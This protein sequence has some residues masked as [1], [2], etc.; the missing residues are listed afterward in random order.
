MRDIYEHIHACRY[1]LGFFKYGL[2]PKLLFHALQITGRFPILSPLSWFPKSKE[3]WLVVRLVRKWV[4]KPLTDS[5]MSSCE[6]LVFPCLW[7]SVERH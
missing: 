5:G 2:W 1:Q 4:V 3:N 6:C 7:L